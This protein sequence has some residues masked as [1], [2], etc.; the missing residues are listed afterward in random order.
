MSMPVETPPLVRHRPTFSD[1]LFLAFLVLVLV[2]V[3]GVGRMAYAEG[4]KNEVSKK[5]ALAWAT[6]LEQAGTD[7]F[8]VGFEL[9][10]C[11]GGEAATGQTWAD[12]LPQLV[13]FTGPLSDMH[14]PFTQQPLVFAAK[15]DPSN[16]SLAGAL[17]IEK[18]VPTAPGSVVP[19]YPLPLTDRDAIDQKMQL[20]VTTCD[21][22][23]YPGK[24]TE[25]TF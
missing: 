13:G 19:F 12:C 16:K 22:G 24:A 14:N 8:K 11:A 21:Q 25:V 1:S 3:A 6:W 4:L 20:R 7:R 2:A 15:C 18:L 5:N 9:S 10:G 23:A 17:V